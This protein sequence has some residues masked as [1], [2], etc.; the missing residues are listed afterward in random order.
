VIK[1][2]N[3]MKKIS[4]IEDYER[5]KKEFSFQ[6]SMDVRFSET[7]MFGH[8]NNTVPFIYFEQARIAYFKELGF[9]EDWTAVHG[10]SIPVVADLQCDYI[11]QVFFDEHITVY[12]KAQSIGTTSVDLHYLGINEKKEEVFIGRGRIVHISKKSGTPLAW[13]DEMVTKF[14]EC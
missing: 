11:K 8:L 5:W 1:G 10:E 3:N 12:V 6:I 13:S 9:M 4:Y 7:D 14:K 2:G